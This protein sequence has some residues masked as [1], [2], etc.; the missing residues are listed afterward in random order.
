MRKC[1]VETTVS[2]IFP[3]AGGPKWREKGEARRASGWFRHNR[4]CSCTFLIGWK[5][6]SPSEWLRTQSTG[7]V[8]LAWPLWLIHSNFS[9]SAFVG[10]VENLFK[11]LDFKEGI[12]I[13]IWKPNKTWMILERLPKPGSDVLRAR[14]AI[15]GKLRILTNTFHRI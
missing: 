9:T 10:I 1:H 11:E 6:S 15:V 12:Q 14:G 7:N 5:E 8:C 4:K 2:A 13:C 3:L